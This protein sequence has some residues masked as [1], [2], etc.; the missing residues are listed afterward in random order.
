MIIVMGEFRLKPEYLDNLRPEIE[1]MVNMSN[2]ESGCIYFQFS[3]ALDDPGLMRLSEK[4]KSME[5][6]EIHFQSA[7]FKRW[8]EAISENGGATD[9]DVA[10]YEVTLEKDLS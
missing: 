4:W 2:S 6:L 1:Q 10:A 7:H 5:D 9:R 3:E 8:R